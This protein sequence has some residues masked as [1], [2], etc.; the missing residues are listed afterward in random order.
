MIQNIL[1]IAVAL[2]VL[3]TFHE[4]GHYFIA[5]RCGV[6]VLRFSIGFGKPIYTYTNSLGTQFT[7]A[8][9]P[10]GGY[11]RMLDEREANVPPEQKA[12]AFNNK[13]VWQR[14]AI[15]A[16]GPLANFLLA[17]IL[18]VIVALQG[19]Q[20]VAP[21]VGA[22][23]SGSPVAATTLTAGDELTAIDGKAVSSWEQTNLALASLIGRTES[24]AIRYLKAG[25]TVETEDYVQ[26]N[27]W[28]VNEE[29]GNLITAF[30]IEVSQPEIPAIVDGVVNNGA[31]QD[32]GFQVND[33]VIRV[34]DELLV[35]WPQFVEIVQRNPL[36][37]LEVDVLRGN[38]EERLLLTPKQRVVDGKVQGYIG[39]RVAPVQL[40]ESWY[41]VTQYNIA[42]ALY[43]GVNKTAQMISLTLGSIGK[44][45]Q[46]LISIDNLS[47]PITIAKVA[48][49]SAESGLQSFLQFLA[50]LSVSLGVLN[51]LPIP[52]LDGGHLLFYSLEAIRRK[53]VTDRVQYLAYKVGASLLFALMAIAVFN[54]ITRL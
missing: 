25:S 36:N 46:G 49:A 32:A 37:T 20:F 27:A 12:Q 26:L 50:Y 34:N 15:V 43:Y 18:Y 52:V 2:G 1:S 38:K 24:I 45:L 39:M 3:I 51:L 47:G 41:R 17:V 5:R 53:P 19:I 6:K 7:L 10:L 14:I 44:M 23:I 54:D 29:P 42:E 11:V 33:R 22:V 35:D 4:F 28:L 48:S 21:T 31:A 8:L 9:I 16:A 30:G 40:D 13:T